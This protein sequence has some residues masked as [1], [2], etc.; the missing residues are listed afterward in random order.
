MEGHKD[1]LG[2]WMSENEGAKF[3]LSVLTDLQTRGLKDILIVCVDRA[4]PNY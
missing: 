1:V 4:V 2:L 3:W